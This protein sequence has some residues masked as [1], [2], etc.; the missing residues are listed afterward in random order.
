MAVNPLQ[1]YVI[2][3]LALKVGTHKF[4]FVADDSFFDQFPYSIVKK[5]RVEVS[6]LLD[7]QN[8]SYFV[9][10]FYLAGH[11]E[12]NCDRCLDIYN[13]PLEETHDLYVKLS[14]T[15]GES[16]DEELIL[17]PENAYELDVSPFVYEFINLSVP[18][19]RVCS[20]VGKECNP[21]MLSHIAN[22]DSDDD[23][24]PQEAQSAVSDERWSAL[25]GLHSQSEDDENDRDDD[26]NGGAGQHE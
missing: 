22:A 8:E 13:L 20:S 23:E 26:E 9:L 17:L 12:V 16:D 25:K 18:L 24:L 19:R 5:G 10:H 2:R 21:A 6:L 4:E 15:G 11:I 3:F 7:K 1:E 14:G